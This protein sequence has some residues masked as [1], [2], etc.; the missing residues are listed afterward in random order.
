MSFGQT[1]FGFS[2]RIARLP[3]LCYGVLASS[4]SLLCIFVGA[5]CFDLGDAG[6][7]RS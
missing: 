5:F 1:Q 7:I 3:Y 6:L 4:L 2:G